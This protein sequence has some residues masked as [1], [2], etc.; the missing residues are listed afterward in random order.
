MV[1]QQARIGETVGDYRLLKWFGGGSFGNVYLAEH[2][3]DHTQVAIKV[4]A[5]RLTYPRDLRSFL[6]EARTFRLRHPHI[7]PL[8]DFGL[9]RQDEPFLV[10]DY[11]PNGTLRDRHPKGSRVPLPTVVDYATQVGSALQYAHDQRLVHR[12]VKP[13]NLLLRSDRVVLLSDFGIA[14][15]AHSTDSLSTSEG[16]SGTALYMAPEQW[17][18][19]PLPQSDQYALAVVI[20][21]WLTGRCPFVG[22]TVFEVM[23]QH[24]TKL[25]PSLLEQ[26]PDLSSEIEEVLFHA[27]AKNPKERFASIRAF[28][29][30][31]RQANALPTLSQSIPSEAVGR[32]RSANLLPMPESSH[33]P[34]ATP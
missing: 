8:L 17:K 14:T 9:S 27:L 22:N 18:G 4:L 6:N 21:E 7:M 11:A 33:L 12:D 16:V 19:K 3:H 5:M 25:P 30:A 13:E 20:Y 24:D 10:M 1:N 31:L 15:A 2:L 29:N 23:S 28:I 26:V 32:L 34:G